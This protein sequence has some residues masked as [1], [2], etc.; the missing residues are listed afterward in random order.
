[1]RSGKGRVNGGAGS[2]RV[3]ARGSGIG[4]AGRGT[5]A[6]RRRLRLRNQQ[7]TDLDELK[8]AFPPVVNDAT[9]VLVL[10]SLPGEESLARA[11]YYAN[12]R[13]HFWRLI[14]AVVGR[15]LESLAYEERLAALLAAGVGLWDTVR[16]ARRRGSLDGN[17]RDLEANPLPMIVERLPRLRAVGFNGGRSAS[18]GMV[19][20]AGHPRLTLIALPSSSPAYTLP[21]AAKLERW[22]ALRP[23][24]E[25]HSS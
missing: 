4:S 9:R 11:Q 8:R 18:L 16:A 1:V 20:L 5:G 24:L 22:M 12:P 14:G 6:D 23:F 21:F 15:P 10:G 19:Q 2:I 7:G 25:P 13:N 17:I 3:Q